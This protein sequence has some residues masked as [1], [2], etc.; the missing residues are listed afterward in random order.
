[1]EKVDLLVPATLVAVLLEV[2]CEDF[3]PPQYP[4]SVNKEQGTPTSWHPLLSFVSLLARP[5]WVTTVQSLGKQH[6]E[7]ETTAYDHPLGGE[8]IDLTVEV[9]QGLLPL[10]CAHAQ[11]Y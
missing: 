4:Q 2:D 6:K 9:S 8:T 11:T 7:R 1:M 5:L 10:S 3:L